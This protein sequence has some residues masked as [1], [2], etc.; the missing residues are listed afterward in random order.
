MLVILMALVIWQEASPSL[1]RFGLSFLFSQDW[2]PV[3]GNFGALPYVFGTLVSTFLALLLAGPISLGAAVFLAEFA[4]RRIKSTLSFMVDILAAVPSIIY[5]LWGVFVLVPL[6]QYTVE[7][8]LGRHLGFLPFFQGP[9][10]GVGML[11]AGIILAIMIS[12]VITAVSREVLEIVPVSQREAMLAMGATRWEVV[13]VAVL[14]YAGRGIIGAFTLGLGK[15]IGETLAV[16]MVIGNRPDI[17]WSLFAQSHTM[18]SVLINE[19]SEAVEPLHRAALIHIA[20]LLFLVTLVINILARL[21]IY[22]MGWKK[23]KWN[24]SIK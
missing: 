13:R 23:N 14:P 2:N 3:K 12:P 18:T 6:L 24:V 5:G 20:L 1:Q 15:A 7:P 4:P 21:M 11:A 22:Q 8:F 10:Y 19:F 9:S 17:S 16:T